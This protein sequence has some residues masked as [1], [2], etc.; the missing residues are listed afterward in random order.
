MSF[1]GARLG[2]LRPTAVYERSW[3]EG[4][5]CF[6][7]FA[8]EALDHA[9]LTCE[10]IEPE[11][12]SG[13][14]IDVL[15][16]PQ[17]G[18]VR[19]SDVAGIVRLAEAGG[20]V[21][22]YGSPGA[23]GEHFGLRVARA[24]GSGYAC[25]PDQEDAPP[26]RFLE[27]HATTFD[28]KDSL[29]SEWK[30]TGEL[31]ATPAG[32]PVSPA[33]LERSVGEGSIAFCPADVFESMV[34]MQQGDKPVTQDGAPA[35][36]GTV[37]LD[38]GILK[39]EETLQLDWNW[40]RANTPSGTP[41]FRTPYCDYWREA[42]VGHLIRAALRR[43]LTL[44]FLWYW[45]DPYESV[46]LLSHDSDQ[47]IDESATTTL[48]FLDEHKINSTWCIIKP[49]F[50]GDTYDRVKAAGHELAFHYNA[51]NDQG[52]KWS[53][54]EFKSQFSWLKQATELDE[55]P[56]NKNHYTRFEGWSEL[57]GWCEDCGIRVDQTRGP[58]KLGDRGF[59]FG[60]CHPYRPVAWHD[61]RNRLYDV[62]EVGFLTQ[63]LDLSDHWG[64]SDVLYPLLDQ[65][66]RVSGV[67]H[68]LFHQVHIHR[69]EQ[70][71]QALSTLINEARSRGMPWWTS[72]Q[73]GAWERAR[74]GV[75]LRLSKDNEGRTTIE[76]SSRSELRNAVIYIP[77]GLDNAGES[78]EGTVLR[79]GFR[80]RRVVCDLKPGENRVR[81]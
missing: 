72:A 45:P 8:V 68:F 53:E 79:W 70:V 14:R 40:D 37:P 76:A 7:S 46:A 2:V 64:R 23:L 11:A 30:R 39:A 26:L 52:G 12:V 33:W 80:C 38:D 10:P 57:F 21:I 65:V 67:A 74:R 55:I 27:G 17:G 77:A 44:P 15:L 4:G 32:E 54:D 63:D 59:L 16:I 3:R 51:H 1:D 24:T 34:L 20:S 62:L 47:N 22:Q 49:G 42:V 36:D 6:D 5:N 31:R 71:R 25:F 35:P 78:S 75:S 18:T 29:S 9:G 69:S 43:G 81:I 60:T 73:V 56:S 48:E 50:G 19:E 58:S 66:Q 13:D 61:E 28:G 41:Y